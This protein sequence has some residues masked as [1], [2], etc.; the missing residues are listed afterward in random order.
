M[1]NLKKLRQESI[2]TQSYVST[3]LCPN[4]GNTKLLLLRTLNRKYCT[5]CSTEIIWLLADTQKGLL[6]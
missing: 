1:K 3:K 5:E 2:S 4:C 6:A